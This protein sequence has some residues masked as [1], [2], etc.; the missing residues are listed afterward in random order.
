[1][2]KIDNLKKNYEG[3][4]LDCSMEVKPG[5]ITGLI[6]L[7]GAG[8][9]TVFK[10]A[11]GLV[12]PASGNIEIFGKDIRNFGNGDRERVGAV[13]SD[14]GFSGFL[15][16]KDI[17]P[18]LDNLYS[19]FDPGLFLERTE[20]AGLPCDKRI[21]DFSTGMKA[22]LKVLSAVSHGA[23][24]LIL[25]EPTA[26][27]D[28]IA[29]DEVLDIV[30]DY[31]EENEE[32]AVLISSHI[33]GD[34]ES[35][36]DDLYMIDKGRIIFHEETDVILSD[37]GIIKADEEMYSLLDKRFILATEKKSYGYSLL[38]NE[39]RYYKENYPEI[40][41]EKGTVDGVIKSLIGGEKR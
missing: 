23:N 18:V 17:V 20:K 22:K 33:S 13:L 4:S 24:L 29:R 12:F 10:S 2:L 37:Y 6:G 27:L 14:S 15:R 16:I 25:D 28:V 3:F 19:D 32:N 8:K 40:T 41:A 39:I 30:R 21:K 34:L 9:T 35:L 11:L 26:G 38:T 36:C 7:N 1:M 31:M 5:N